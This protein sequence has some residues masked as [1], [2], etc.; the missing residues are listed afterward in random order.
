MH[1]S[2]RNWLVFAG[3]TTLFWGVWGAFIEVPEKNGLPATL[4]F[5]VWALTMIIPAVISLKRINWKI[6]FTRQSVFYGCIIGFTGAGGQL[7]LFTNAL[8]LGPA[9]LIFPIISL[10]PVITIFLSMVF[11]KER[12]NKIVWIGIVLAMLSI[13]LLSYVS[14]ESGVGSGALW[15][16][17]ALIVFAAW[18]IQ[19]FFM[20]IANQTMKAEEIFFYMTVTGLI[21]IP[22]ALMMTDFSLPINYGLDGMYL[23]AG[24]QLLNAFG[25]LTLV[26]A[27][28]YGKAI[29][30]SPLTNSAAPLLTVLISLMIYGHVPNSVVIAGMILATLATFLISFGEELKSSR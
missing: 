14:P 11:L 22:L 9:Y 29:I 25:A 19:A 2:N 24:I 17:F 5:S 3:I 26:F 28:R 13:P 30:V 27:F 10:S 6:N 8:N 20:K 16:I 4:G 12:T 21:M 18:G 15:L 23:A 7:I 1:T